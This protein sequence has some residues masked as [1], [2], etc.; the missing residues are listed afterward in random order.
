MI[1]HNLGYPRIGINRDLKKVIEPYWKGE[2]GKARLN[3]S[4]SIF[5]V[6]HWT[7]Q[8]D[9]GIDLVPSNDF[10]LYDQVLDMALLVGAIPD[11]D[12][13]EKEN[14]K[15]YSYP[16]DTSFAMARGLQDNTQVISC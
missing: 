5:K 4:I 10:S 14:D 12:L 15:I 7:T 13:Y 1:T 8:K 11:R 6:M 16:I 2:T 3:E 9:A